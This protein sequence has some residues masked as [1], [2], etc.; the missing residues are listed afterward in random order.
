M[1]PII[2]FIKGFREH[3]KNKLPTLSQTQKFAQAQEEL[4]DK[5]L[6][7]SMPIDTQSPEAGRISATRKEQIQ[8]LTYAIALM[9]KKPK[10]KKF[11]IFMVEGFRMGY[12]TK[13]LYVLAARQLS[14]TVDEIK[15]I[16][17]HAVE[18]AKE[19]LRRIK[20]ENIPIF[21]EI[22]ENDLSDI[23]GKFYQD[24]KN[25][26]SVNTNKPN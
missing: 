3:F 25:D 22:T 4:N 11:L 26:L 6:E 14:T 13:Y 16:E 17:K 5:D 19:E 8:F 2:K 20:S 23:V 9:E 1:N 15:K 10:Y 24:P 18:Y 21:S 7:M 12:N